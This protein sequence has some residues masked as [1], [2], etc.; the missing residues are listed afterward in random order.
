MLA[1]ALAAACGPPAP[2]A[3]RTDAPAVPVVVT[4]ATEKPM[5]VDVS[6]IGNVVPVNT[7]TVR[8]RVTGV[9]ERVHFTEGETVKQGQV[10]FTLDRGPLIAELRRAEA[11]LAASSTQAANA[12]REAERYAELYRRGLVAQSQYDELRSRAETLQGQV[13]ADRA[14]V[15]NARLQVN[16][17]VIRAPLTGRTGALQV[18]Q[19][20]LIEANQTAMVIINQMQPISVAFAIPEQYLGDVRRYSAAGTLRV[21]AVE[22]ATRRAVA[23]GKLTFIDNRVDPATGTVALKA[24]FANDENRL[25]PGEFVDVVLTLTVEPSAVVVPTAAVQTGQDGRFVYVV[26]A[27]ETAELR[28]VTVAREVGQE[29]VIAS[30]VTPGETVVLETAP[31]RIEAVVLDLGRDSSTMS[32]EDLTARIDAAIRHANSGLTPDERVDAWRMWPDADFPRTHTMKIQR[33]PVRDWVIRGPDVAPDGRDARDARD[34][35]PLAVGEGSVA[36]A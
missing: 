12:A 20:D 27:D 8:S 1:A 26:T 36:Q 21:T 17:G 34:D 6:A 4:T 10:L 9:L 3:P 33:D 2:D 29:A 14:V 31:G 22:P 32:G 7:V 30:G 11:A 25:W 13:R 16:Y 35:S 24:T 23:S 18:H 19:G 28:P 15:E 5:P